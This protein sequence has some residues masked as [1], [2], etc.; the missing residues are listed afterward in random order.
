MISIFKF[1][2]NNNAKEGD[3]RNEFI[4]RTLL[5]IAVISTHYKKSGAQMPDHGELW[6]CKIIK[7]IQ[8]GVNRGC[9]IVEPIARVSDESIIHLFPGAYEQK[10][11]G[12]RILIFPNKLGPNLNWIMPLTHKRMLAEEHGAYAVIVRLDEQ[13]EE[14]SKAVA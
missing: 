10:I 9:F 11:V 4:S 6:Q 13:T 7:E 1:F 3:H 14:K 2:R 12:G 8:S 5:K